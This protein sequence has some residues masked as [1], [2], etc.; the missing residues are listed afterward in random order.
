VTATAHRAGQLPQNKRLR[1]AGGTAEGYDTS[2]PYSQWDTHLK[3]ATCR[4]LR[5]AKL[6]AALDDFIAARRANFRLPA[7]TPPGVLFFWQSARSV[8]HCRRPTPKVRHAW[9]GFRMVLRP[10]RVGGRVFEASGSAQYR[11]SKKSELACCSP[12]P[13]LGSLTNAG[14]KL[15]VSRR[16]SAIR[17][18]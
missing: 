16:S 1:D 4:R 17:I 2:T 12:A 13:G 8:L 3:I 6:R 10:E 5:V 14:S 9:F 15:R 11:D 18:A 7:R